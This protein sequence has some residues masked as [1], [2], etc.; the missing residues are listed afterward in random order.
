MKTIKNVGYS[1]LIQA[2]EKN[3]YKIVDSLDGSL[4]DNVL[5]IKEAR[6]GY[7]PIYIAGFETFLNCCSSA[8]KVMI[9][10]TEKDIEKLL[11]IWG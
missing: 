9:A 8:L 5:Y 4:I 7:N 10:R 11:K 6:P 3:G 1:D 2:L